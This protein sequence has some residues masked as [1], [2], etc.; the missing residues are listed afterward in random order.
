VFSGYRKQRLLSRGGPFTSSFG[1]SKPRFKGL[2]VILIGF[3]SKC[4]RGRSFPHRLSR[5]SEVEMVGSQ[6]GAVSQIHSPQVLRLR[7]QPIK[8]I[9]A[10]PTPYRGRAAGRGTA[11]KLISAGAEVPTL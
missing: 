8:P 4:E 10:I 11:D 9:T 7:R 6:E 1:R 5:M 2:S 3:L